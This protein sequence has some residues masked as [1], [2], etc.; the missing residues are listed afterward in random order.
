MIAL[1]SDVRVYLACGYTDMRKGMLRARS[2]PGRSATCRYS[3]CQASS[4]PMSAQK[5][6]PPILRETLVHPLPGRPGRSPRR[7]P[8]P[9]LLPSRRLCELPGKASANHAVAGDEI[10][11]LF[12][13]PAFGTC[14]PHWNNE[15]ADFC[16]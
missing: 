1:H 3:I 10:N 6:G 2:S 14:W 15:V 7:R 4:S 13:V 16:G 5:C 8:S 9:V 11:K 12:F